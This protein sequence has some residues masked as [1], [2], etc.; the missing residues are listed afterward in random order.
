[1]CYEIQQVGCNFFV[2]ARY[3][4]YVAYRLWQHCFAA[5]YDARGN[6]DSAW[7]RAEKLHDQYAMLKEIAPFV[8]EGSYI[9]MQGEDFKRWRWAFY[10]GKCQR[11][12]AVFL[13]LKVKAQL[14]PA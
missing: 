10:G 2:E 12:C 11:A 14:R 13:R 5:H 8:R 3:A 1:M 6:I 7:F 9:E 4:D